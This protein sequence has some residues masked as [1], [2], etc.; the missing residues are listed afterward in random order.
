VS[1]TSTLQFITTGGLVLYT[2][3]LT[4]GQSW[5]PA[6]SI[7]GTIAYGL[8][9]IFNFGLE[10]LDIAAPTNYKPGVFINTATGGTEFFSNIAHRNPPTGLPPNQLFQ[11][12]ILDAKNVSIE[13]GIVFW[14]DGQSGMIF[15]ASDV[16]LNNENGKLSYL[17]RDQPRNAMAIWE[18]VD[19]DHLEDDPI[20]AGTTRVDRVTEPKRG[21]IRI[22]QA[23]PLAIYND[24]WA[25]KT[26]PPWADAGNAGQVWPYAAGAVR[27]CGPVAFMLNDGSPIY[28][29]HLDALTKIGDERDKGDLLD[30]TVDPP[31]YTPTGDLRGTIVRVQPVG[32]FTMSVS[33]SGTSTLTPVSPTDLLGGV[34]DMATASGGAGSM[35]T[36]WTNASTSGFATRTISQISTDGGRMSIVWSSWSGVASI[37]NA[38][39]DVRAAATITAADRYRISIDVKSLTKGAHFRQGGLSAQLVDSGGTVHDLPGAIWGALDVGNYKADFTAPVAAV[40]AH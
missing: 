2:V 27:N 8:S 9:G 40:P 21:V 25:R 38:N 19:L 17:L 6:M 33:S 29:A 34:G 14:P 5:I 3:T 16:D 35:P 26:I 22:K 10:P 39:A 24:A 23:S 15:G 36:G 18:L 12:V 31:D 30:P 28:L 4:A 7:G 37:M 32:K 13:S 20:R 1:G 11:G